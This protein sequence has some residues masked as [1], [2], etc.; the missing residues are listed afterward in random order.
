VLFFGRIFEVVSDAYEDLIRSSFIAFDEPFPKRDYLVP[1]VHVDADYQQPI[2][3]GEE[4]RVQLEIIRIGESSMA[5][6]FLVVGADDKACVSG[7]V[8]HTFVDAGTFSTIA[9]PDEVR[10]VL[11]RLAEA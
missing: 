10:S 8:V 2:R 11:E 5:Y 9:M 1:I 4:V 6:N 3:V 7:K